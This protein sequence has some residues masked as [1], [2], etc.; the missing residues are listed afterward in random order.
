MINAETQL[1]EL[2]TGLLK[3]DATVATLKNDLLIY[4]KEAAEL[5]IELN[6]V[7][8]TL[9]TAENLVGKLKDEYGRWKQQASV[10]LYCIYICKYVEETETLLLGDKSKNL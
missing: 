7:Q 3:V 1:S 9:T 5:E 8:N 4:T 6:K 2:S 10:T